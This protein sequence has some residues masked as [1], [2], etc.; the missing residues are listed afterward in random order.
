MTHEERGPVARTSRGAVRGRVGGGAAAFLGIP[1]AEPPVGPR[2]WDRPERRR[3]WTGVRDATAFGP[4]CWQP[5]GGPLD[6]L[7]PG[8]GAP[9]QG[10]DCLSVNVWTP[11]SDDGRRPVMVWVHGGAFSLGAGSLPV[12]DGALLAAERD[13]VVVTF[14][15][16][17]GALGFLSLEGAV[18]EVGLL[19]QVA[20]L[21]WVRDE[22][23]VF[24]GDPGCVT[25][26]GESAGAGSVLSLLAMP[27]AKG[28]VHRAVVQSGAT[29]LLLDRDRARLVAGAFAQAAGVDV[30]DLDALRALPGPE[31]VAAQARAAAALFATVGTMP[32]HPC[33][34]GEVLPHSW[35]DAARLGTNPVPLVIGTTRDE[36]AL[37]AGLDPSSG[38]LDD[39]RLAR[40]LGRLGV[41][42]P[43]ATVALYR[44]AGVDTA[45]AIWSRVQTDTQM[46][47][48]ALR[49]A[50]AHA[51]HAP[52]WMYRF[53][54]PAADPALGACH[55]VDIPFPFG[56]TDTSGWGEF[57]GDPTG[58]ARLSTTIRGLWSSLARD[59]RPTS[60][61]IDWPRYY[62]ARAT[63]VLDDRIEVVTDPD[64]DLRRHWD[65]VGQTL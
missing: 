60:T 27:A 22:I 54:R 3:P 13:V 50:E 19:D 28:L 44:A 1:Y 5:G 64:G 35:L 42:D 6:G 62:D 61:G 23:A 15:Y 56:S 49:I 46:W 40:R 26:F 7:V 47:L 34:D 24:G 25:V 8:M 17:L 55:G 4:A 51:R 38:S 58:A 39:D 32:F 18:A 16:R 59:G 10:D 20:V 9:D 36:M 63:L 12:Y 41:A 48:P 45:P 53:D 43:A 2:R 11:A 21:E 29:D 65:D 52:V 33:V 30:D 37:F 57:L 31:V 14:N